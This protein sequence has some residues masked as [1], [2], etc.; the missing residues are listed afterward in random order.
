MSYDKNIAMAL[1]SNATNL[2]RRVSSGNKKVAS[3]L[4]QLTHIK[5]LI[6]K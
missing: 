1:Y 4:E 5:Y 6:H 3:Q 2:N